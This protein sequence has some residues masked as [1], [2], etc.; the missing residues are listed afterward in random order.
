MRMINTCEVE[1]MG[2]EISKMVQD[3][4]AQKMEENGYLLVRDSVDLKL[5]PSFI[6]RGIKR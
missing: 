2:A 5:P 1:F 4:V 6:F 3:K